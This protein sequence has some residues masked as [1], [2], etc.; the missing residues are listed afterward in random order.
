MKNDFSSKRKLFTKMVIGIAVYVLAYSIVM[1]IFQFQNISGNILSTCLPATIAGICSFLTLSHDIR[2]TLLYNKEAI[3]VN[4]PYYII[5]VILTA[6]S[7]TIIFNFVFSLIPWDVFGSENIVQDNDAFYSVPLSFRIIA[8]VLL[9]PLSEE[10]LFRGVIYSHF[11]EILPFWAAALLTG[12]MFGLYHGNLMQGLY[13]FFMGTVMCLI[14]YYGG[15][16]IYPILFHMVAN[17]VSNLCYEYE[18]IYKV[19]YSPWG[20]ALA[21]AYLVVAIIMSYVF[22]NRLTLKDK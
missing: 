11:K 14:L 21:F 8:Y 1:L 18:H 10:I 3:F 22:K 20:I 13:G 16:F 19:V 9:I 7:L 4:K 6:I 5:F 15:T 17:L 2:K 12:L